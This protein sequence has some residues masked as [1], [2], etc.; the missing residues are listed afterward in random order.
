MNQT[1]Y[2]CLEFNPLSAKE[3]KWQLHVSI[4]ENIIVW[5][6]RGAEKQT[7]QAGKLLKRILPVLISGFRSQ[8]TFY[9]NY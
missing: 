9:I 6:Y 2:F 3:T 7:S 8:A 5:Y 1:K 4:L